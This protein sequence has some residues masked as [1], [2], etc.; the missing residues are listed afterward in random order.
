MREYTKALEA[1]QAAESADTANAHTSEIHAQEL[2]IQQAL[3]AQ[4]A[5]E[6][7]EQ[8]LERAMRDPEV[9]KIM[10]D[11]VMQQIL[12]QAQ[13]NPAALQDHMKSPIIREKIMKLVNAGII[14]TR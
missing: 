3:F 10:S 7:E 4:R 6:T 9:S 1:L 5:E 2:K 12:Q 8:T 11:P 13:G 14:K